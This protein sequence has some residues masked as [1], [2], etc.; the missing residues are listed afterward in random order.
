MDYIVI[1]SGRRTVGLEITPDLQLLVRAPYRCPAK[2]IEQVVRSHE[3]WIA[4]AMERVRQRALEHPPA[5]PEQ[6]VQLRAA[7]A[8]QLPPLVQRYAAQLGL[9]P[10]S[11]RVTGAR[12]RFGSCSPQDR[13]CFSFHLMEYPLPAIEYVVVHELCHIRH[14]NHGPEFYRLV[15]SVL[16]DYRA[17]QALLRPEKSEP[18]GRPMGSG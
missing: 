7:A 15:A 11:V 12:T 5:T 18:P 6:E 3:G 9:Y 14:K 13:I 10:Q 17:R 2:Q 1:R 16:P 8:E 4:H